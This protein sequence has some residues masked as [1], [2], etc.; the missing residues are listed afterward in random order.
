M[1][2]TATSLA[3]LTLALAANSAFAT[4]CPGTPNC[5]GTTGGTTATAGA[6]STTGAVTAN[7]SA[8]SGASSTTGPVTANPTATSGAVAATGPVT[9]NPTATSGAVAATGPVTANGGGGGHAG[10]VA[11]GGQAG[12][13]AGGG[14]SQAATGAITSSP[15]LNYNASTKVWSIVP[16][17]T[18]SGQVASPVINA[19]KCMITEHNQ[20]KYEGVAVNL[21]V[22]GFAVNG[23]G[24]VKTTVKVDQKCMDGVLKSAETVATTYANATVSA[25]LEISRGNVGVAV[26]QSG[27]PVG[28]AAVVQ[29]YFAPGVVGAMGEGGYLALMNNAAF[30]PPKKDEPKKE[31]P[32]PRASKPR[33]P[34]VAAA[35]PAAATA[36]AGTLVIPQGSSIIVTQGDVTATINRLNGCTE[37]V[38]CKVEA[39]PAAPA[40]AASAAG[41]KAEAPGNN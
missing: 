25:A 12:A 23:N 3:A 10:A 17:T 6:S 37:K 2:R 1:S 5:P 38:A 41:R 40:G 21:A 33:N 22:V 30:Q 9:A 7:P 14:T 20:D 35:K 34:T 31:D 29:H 11:G 32:K 4:N 24:A 8:T 28:T 26:V 15:Q 13:V 27:N 39:V 16:P 18:A 19:A 36:T